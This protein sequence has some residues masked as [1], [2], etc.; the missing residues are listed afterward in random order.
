MMLIITILVAIATP[1]F[2]TARE[3]SRTKSC[4]SSLKQID[5]AK[6]Q[7]AMDNKKVNGDLPTWADLSPLYIR[8]QPVCPC[9]GTY[10]VNAIGT[11]PTC[12][13]PAH[14]LL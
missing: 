13:F 6:E 7:W 2:V 8:T 10:G 5:M 9:S 14:V 12:T 4:V 3:N 1:N 11:L